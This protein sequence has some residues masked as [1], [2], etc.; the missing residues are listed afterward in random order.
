[1]VPVYRPLLVLRW[2]SISLILLLFTFR[3]FTREFYEANRRCRSRSW[4]PRTV[5]GSD[6]QQVLCRTVVVGE[7]EVQV[8][9]LDALRDESSFGM[10]DRGLER[11][12]QSPR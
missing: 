3:V 4:E 6:I 7:N 10:R 12:S 9:G 1:M 5:H 11:S 8:Q 2:L